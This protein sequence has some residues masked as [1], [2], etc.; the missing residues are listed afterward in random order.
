MHLYMLMNF[1]YID[2]GPV[3]TQ[4]LKKTK[5]KDVMGKKVPP[6]MDGV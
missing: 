4:I 5:V 3:A 6:H 1:L 2:F